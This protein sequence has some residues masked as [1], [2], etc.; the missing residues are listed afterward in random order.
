MASTQGICKN[1][2][3]LIM[4][5]DREELC[6][7]LFC[8]CVFPTSEA[9][10]IL[11]N[12]GAYT[13]P[14]EPQ[15]KREGVKRYNVTPVYPDPIPAAVKRA[16]AEAPKKKAE[17]N[18]Y[19][20]SPDDIKAPRKTLAW[21]LG[22]S[23]GVIVLVVGIC[24]PLYSAR[25][26]HRNQLSSDISPVFSEFKV[27]TS[28]ENGYTVGFSLRGQS[29]NNL[30]V[31]TS[32]DVTNDDVLLTFKNF[33]VLR[34]KEYGIDENNFANCYGNVKL[35]VY[36]ANGGFT[37]DVNQESDLTADNVTPLS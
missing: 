27:D 5:N 26:T 15:P 23:I 4:L 32:E 37:L 17:K 20:V 19:E 13:F 22:I 36:A 9:L 21:V 2:G 14:N 3:S 1:C 11:K 7:C 24:W 33:A 34:A 25:V 31:T 35:T 30:A 8:D 18:P 16:E 28:E 29:N 12:P 10:E 6:E